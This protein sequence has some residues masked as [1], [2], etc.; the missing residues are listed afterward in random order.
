LADIDDT[1]RAIL[2]HLQDGVYMVD[3]TRR[4][5]YWNRGAERLS[6]YTCEETVGRSCGDGLLIHTDE[7][8]HPLC[9]VACPVAATLQDGQMREA[10]VFLHHRGG[11]RVPVAIR[12]A[13][14][15]DAEGRITAV[16]EVFND[17]SARLA[18]ETRAAELEQLA[19]LDA[20]TGLPNR[21][22]LEA[23]LETRDY[24]A[25]RYGWSFGAVMADIDHFKQ[26]NDTYGHDVG[27]DVLKM[28]GQTL[29]KGSRDTDTVGRW[30][31]EEFLV[32]V[33]HASVGS[34][35]AL[36]NR[37]RGLVEAS[38]LHRAGVNLHVTASL[39]AALARPDEDLSGLIKRADVM[40]YR[41]KQRGRNR[42]EVDTLAA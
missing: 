42:V 5:T 18:V 12:V 21:L 26:V 6:G 40:L 28:V 37:L 8:G 33:P 35:R 17:D 7:T 20:L 16:V 10:R 11:Y 27:D 25:R 41:G 39:G 24:E 13:P 1:Y 14:L 15:Q 2:D 34:L 4:I 22:A 36:A 19:H 31:G 30:G 29:L 9:E 38:S 23:A 32:V 3:A